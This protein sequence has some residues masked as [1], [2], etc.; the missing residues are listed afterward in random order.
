MSYPSKKPKQIKG[1][2]HFRLA[3]STTPLPPRLDR[4]AHRWSSDSGSWTFNFLYY[5]ENQMFSIV[6]LFWN[7]WN[8]SWG[9]KSSKARTRKFLWMLPLELISEMIYFDLT[10]APKR[11]SHRKLSQK[12]KPWELKISY[13]AVQTTLPKGSI[14]WEAK[15]PSYPLLTSLLTLL[16]FTF[17]F[18]DLHCGLPLG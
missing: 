5:L 18:L 1:R 16:N 4:A 7:C 9:S 17:F 8:N 14:P 10:K 3:G 15:I 13:S 12:L 11:V 2:L 6:L